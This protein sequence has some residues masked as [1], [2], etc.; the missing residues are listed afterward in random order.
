[1]EILNTKQIAETLGI[2]ECTCRRLLKEGKIPAVKV[3]SRF[4]TTREVLE[5]WFREN[6]RTNRT[7]T[8]E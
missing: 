3:G 5:D 1:M 6:A 7:L 8:T 2:S 4:R